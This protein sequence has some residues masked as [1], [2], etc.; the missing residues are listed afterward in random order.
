ML[1]SSSFVHAI[2]MNVSACYPIN[3]K[4]SH[5]FHSN[6]KFSGNVNMILMLMSIHERICK[7][8]YVREKHFLS[9]FCNI[10]ISHNSENLGP[11]WLLSS[12][13]IK[14]KGLNAYTNATIMPSSCHHDPTKLSGSKQTVL[15]GSMVHYAIKP[16][17]KEFSRMTACTIVL[18]T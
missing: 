9:S 17:T 10:E 8:C 2:P 12:K 7:I 5:Y 13:R 4:L 6:F 14:K 15:P 1:K 3:Q 16:M 18:I 11:M